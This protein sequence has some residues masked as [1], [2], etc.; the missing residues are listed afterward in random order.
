M[1]PW[2]YTVGIRINR[3][4]TSGVIELA[5]AKV[6]P[7]ERLAVWF[8]LDPVWEP[9]ANKGWVNEAGQLFSLSKEE[10]EAKGGGLFRI[11]VLPEAA[12]YTWTD[13]KRMSGASPA[14]ITGLARAARKVRSDPYRWR[15][16]FDPVPKTLWA[17]IHVW[18]DGAWKALPGAMMAVWRKEIP[19]RNPAECGEATRGAPHTQVWES[20]AVISR[21]THSP[22]SWPY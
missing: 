5:T 4:I 9:T 14:T 16:S 7:G 19:C 3:I 22:P 1:A 10:T 21:K 6:P 12:P 15:V 17:G 8:S 11:A 20:P 2:H 13:F 18:K